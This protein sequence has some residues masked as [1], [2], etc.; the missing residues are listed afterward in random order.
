MNIIYFNPDQLRADFVG[1]YGNPIIKTPNIDRLAAEGVRFDQCSVQHTVCTPSRCSFMTGWYPHVR[2][3]RTLWYPLQPD[4]PNTLKYLKQGG[5]EVHWIGKNDLLAQQ[6][7]DDSVT[8]L[9]FTQSGEKGDRNIFRPDQPGYWSFLYGPMPG[10]SSDWYKVE[11]AVELIKSRKPGD[12]PYMLYLPLKFPHCPF[13][14]PQPW[15]DMYDPAELPPMRPSELAGKPVFHELIRKT[16]QLDKLDDAT[17]RKIRAVYMGM[18]SYVDDMLGKL[19]TALD[20]AG[21]TGETALFFFSDHGDWAGDYGLV[22]KWPSGL[23]D[24]LTHVPAI[25]R[26]PGCRQ[27][28]VA[29]EPAELFDIMP[30]TLEL[31]GIECRHTHFARSMMPQLRGQPGDSRRAAFAEGGYDPHEPHCYEGSPSDTGSDTDGIYYPK[32]RLQQEHPEASV[33]CTMIKTG[34]HKLIFRPGDKSEL[35]DLREDPEEL[36]NVY[37]REEYLEVQRQ[38]ERRILEWYLHTSDV[39]PFDR[40]TRGYSSQVRKKFEQQETL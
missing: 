8:A 13:S 11:K 17:F 27:G 4:E 23:G 38:L 22:E 7:F 20:E 36:C 12:P 28:H 3:H 29:G 6:S 19:L 31:A 32:G 25:I 40:Q 33:R 15:Y 1:C 24:C 37:G 21:Q 35:Y 14:C 18:V 9:H 30:T 39:V 2:G 26:A 16:R 5:Y 34:S 10:H